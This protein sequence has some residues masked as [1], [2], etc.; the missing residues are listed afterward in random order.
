MNGVPCV[1]V[2]KELFDEGCHS[3]GGY[4][5]AGDLE[6]KL[7]FP[8]ACLTVTTRSSFLLDAVPAVAFQASNFVSA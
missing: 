3:F 1:Q 2:Q 8:Q 7:H 5:D 4:Q 6:M